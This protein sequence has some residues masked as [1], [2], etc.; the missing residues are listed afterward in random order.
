MFLYVIN[1]HCFS[2]QFS[3]VIT[4]WCVLVAIIVLRHLTSCVLP[5]SLVPCLVTKSVIGNKE[6]CE[7]DADQ[8][9]VLIISQCKIYDFKSLKHYKD[10]LKLSTQTE[11]D[12]S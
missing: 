1:E 4:S 8:F 6:L 3:H 11:K 2:N 9:S 12:Y 5:L 10:I 7:N